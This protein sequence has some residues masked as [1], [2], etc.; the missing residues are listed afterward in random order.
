MNAFDFANASIIRVEEIK[1][2]HLRNKD[3]AKRNQKHRCT[4]ANRPG[5]RIAVELN[6]EYILKGLS[7]PSDTITSILATH[8]RNQD[9][10]KNK[11]D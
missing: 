9:T 1:T 4:N 6:Q 5:R 11:S 3:D 2:K 10:S 8:L 7:F